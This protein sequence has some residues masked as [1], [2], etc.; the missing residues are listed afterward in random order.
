MFA[1]AVM[2]AFDK[3]CQNGNTIQALLTPRGQRDQYVLTSS[4]FYAHQNALHLYFNLLI[5]LNIT[6]KYM[7]WDL[8]LTLRASGF[9]PVS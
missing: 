7:L 1:C 4:Q 6:I 2:F 3:S 9:Q 8:E 5:S